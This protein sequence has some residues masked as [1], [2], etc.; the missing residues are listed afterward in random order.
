MVDATKTEIRSLFVHRVGNKLR[1]E[2]CVCSAKP[3]TLSESEKLALLL[4]FL[5]RIQDADSFK[6]F[7]PIGI[8]MNEVYATCRRAFNRPQSFQKVTAD[9]ASLLYEASSHPKIKAG[10]VYFAFL[11]NISL[12][13]VAGSAIGIFKSETIE[14]FL[15]VEVRT[16]QTA[17][18]V[19]QGARISSVDKV[20]IVF[21]ADGKISPEVLTLCSRGEDAVYWQERFL[22]VIPS[23]SEKSHT[24]D[25]LDLCHAYSNESIPPENASDRAL[26]LNKSLEYFQQ[27]DKFDQ[28]AFGDVFENAEQRKEFEQ[29]RQR[30]EKERGTKLPSTFGISKQVVTRQRKKFQKNLKLDS[31]IEVRLNFDSREEM[32]NHVEHGFDKKKNMSFYKLYYKGNQ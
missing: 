18:E 17:L 3:Q 1:Q 4:F 13:G 9:L 14:R 29:V 30:F 23:G 10:N 8:E 27:S 5:G 16:E 7:H 22:Q 25:Y 19:D 12:N 26:F 28:K 31:N 11:E 32:N 15:K 24:R 2:G 20:A 21:C 6:F